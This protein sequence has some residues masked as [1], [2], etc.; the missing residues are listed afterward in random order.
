MLYIK[1]FVT[2]MQEYKKQK[3]Q[4]CKQEST[5]LM[6]TNKQSTCQLYTNIRWTP[7]FTAHHSEP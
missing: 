1:G 5:Q 4:K 2:L 6:G 3:M 7:L